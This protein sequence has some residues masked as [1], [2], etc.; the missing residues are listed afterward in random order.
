MPQNVEANDKPDKAN[1]NHRSARYNGLWWIAIGGI[2]CFLALLFGG[3]YHP[4]LT[5]RVKFVTVNALSLL[6]LVVVAVQVLF[7][8]RQ[9]DV[10]KRQWEETQR[11]IKS[12][13]ESSISA[14]RAYVVAKIEDI[15]QRDSTLQFRLR[16]ENGGNTPANNVCVFFAS[17]LR[18]SPPW[19][20]ASKQF[21]EMPEKQISF[22]TS[23]S[24]AER[25]GVIAPNGSYQIVST[26]E[27][28]FKSPAEYQRFGY[29]ELN[30][31]CWGRIVYEDIFS[32]KRHTDFCFF[33]SQK[34]PFGYPC[35]HGNKA[36]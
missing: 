9:W 6:V 3:I 18:E 7:N 21:L 17:E 32:Q 25:L 36:N 4:N 16:I 10:M 1:N 26:P 15:G 20:M 35:E 30:F 31:F 23:L 11:G 24:H 5:E 22:D 12:A 28:S 2:I 27:T 19:D 13:E 8:R 33:Q 14:Q 29:G 34:K